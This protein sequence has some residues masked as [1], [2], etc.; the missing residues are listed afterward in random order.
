MATLERIRSKGGVLVA[1]LIGLALL[2]F[3]L[4]DL[5]SSGSYIFRRSQ[6][7]V[8][9]IEGQSISI[10]EF[11]S[12][13][14][15]MEEYAK[16]NSGQSSLDAEMINRLRDQ[17]WNQMVN[18]ILLNAKYEA[19]GISVSPAELLDMVTG[20]QAH[21]MIQ[22]LFTN[23][24][25]GIFD[26]QQVIRFLKSKQY[27]PTA[28]F[29]WNFVEDQLI[30]ERLYE[31]YSTL[32]QKGLYVTN[33]WINSEAKA[34]SQSV[35]FNFVIKRLT[36]VPDDQVSVTEKEI[37][38]Y[39]NDHKETFKQTASRDIEYITFDVEPTD[40]D[41]ENTRQ[42]VLDMK[43]DFSSPD[44]DP[45][46]F[47]KFNSDIPFNS[48]Y[49]KPEALEPEIR[50]FVTSASEGD[51]YGPYFENNTYKLTRLVDIAQLP[52]SVRARHI[53]LRNNPQNPDEAEQ[54]ADSLMNLLKNGA[55]FAE[56]ARQY[57]EDPGSAI[58]GG[59]LGWFRQ[60]QMVQP[61]ND[62]CFFGK[63]GDIV[64]V[65]TNFGWHII[66]IIDKGRATTK[67]QLATLGREVTYSSKTYQDVYSRAT[68]FAALN[69]TVEKFN[70]AIEEQNLTKKYGRNLQKN[71]RFVGNLESPRELVKWAFKADIGELS[72]IFEFGD[73]FVIAVLSNIT[74]EGYMPLDA[75][76]NRIERQL[77]NEKKKEILIK[78][79]KEQKA[80]QSSLEEIAN[81]LEGELH[82]A[83]DVTFNTFQVTGAGT[84]PALVG[85]ALYSPVNEI[86]E[87]V[88][89]NNGVYMVEVTNKKETEVDT[90]LIKNQLKSSLFQ[91]ISYQLLPEIR[92]KAEIID[93]RSNFY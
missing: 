18:E 42:T 33:Q 34:R 48:N 23:P 11:Q 69:N 66:H 6:M 53:L 28:N 14:S 50:D 21:P 67:Y 76:R 3:I 10:Q 19:V 75:V 25:T 79:F 87:P 44:I 36:S 41:R 88:A 62:A 13:V 16:L 85:L 68:R 40:E 43:K 59:E 80:S 61:F 89:G 74:E 47:V 78:Q 37:K 91:K 24:Q 8:A 71:D 83:T 92:E 32:F 7:M 5:L 81:A 58:N 39:Y 64:K 31:K 20:P 86:S 63:K 52:D 45:V 65:E 93:N 90:E 1:V 49:F 46:Q 84:E 38:A 12:R 27:D 9:E 30:N 72:P 35:D 17:A 22:Q 54:L 51:V 60:G 26:K 82:S 77:M 73:Q 2:A 55:D 56:L 29:Y 15:E 4:T 70:Q 57:S